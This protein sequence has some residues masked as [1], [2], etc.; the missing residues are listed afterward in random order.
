[1]QSADASFRVEGDI[2][3]PRERPPRQVIWQGLRRVPLFAFG[4]WLPS[5]AVLVALLAARRIDVVPA[6]VGAAAIFIVLVLALVP[7]IL[8]LTAVQQ[9][10]DT[11]GADAEPGAE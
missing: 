5:A 4:L 1:M 2:A 7:L 6:V 10:I 11:I 8:S 3:T 9:A